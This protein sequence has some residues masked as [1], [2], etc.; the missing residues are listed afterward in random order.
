MDRSRMTTNALD[1]VSRLASNVGDAASINVSL[2]QIDWDIKLVD[3]G[4]GALFARHREIERRL[5]CYLV[6]HSILLRF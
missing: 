6:F 5:C 2:G 4:I 3:Q 1:R